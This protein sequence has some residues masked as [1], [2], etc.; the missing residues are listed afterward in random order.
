MFSLIWSLLIGLV[1]G[2][3]AASI[4]RG[5]SLGWIWN[6]ILGMVGGVVG[7]WVFSLFGLESNGSTIGQVL[8]SVVGACVLLFIGGLFGKKR[9]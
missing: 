4:M 6:T 7:G 9:S 1:A 8:V 5:R 3:I 2:L